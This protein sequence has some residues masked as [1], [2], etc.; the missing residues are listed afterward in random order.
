V[1]FAVVV[2]GVLLAEDRL[3]DWVLAVAAAGALVWL[4][5]LSD[6]SQIGAVFTELSWTVGVA[7]AAG[8]LT[9]DLGDMLT[10]SGVPLLWPLP[11]P[12]G[13]SFETWYEIR[14]PRLVRFRTGGRGEVVVLVLL[15]AGIGWWAWHTVSPTLTTT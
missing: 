11:L 1:V 12:S 5:S 8:C 10:E 4:G 9:H 13:R 14:P 6:P 2:V 7:V 3:G 15:L